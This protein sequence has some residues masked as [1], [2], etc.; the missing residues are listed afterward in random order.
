MN[1]DYII[2]EGG[3]A[4]HDQHQYYDIARDCVIV[5]TINY[6]LR[7]RIGVFMHLFLLCMVKWTNYRHM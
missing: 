5:S 4:Q 1:M 7:V 2:I 3:L 6:L